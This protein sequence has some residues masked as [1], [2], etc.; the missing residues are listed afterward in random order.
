MAA[1]GDPMPKSIMVQSISGA[2]DDPEM[3]IFD[4]KYK[5]A[6]IPHFLGV[7]IGIADSFR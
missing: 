4:V 7:G 3:G 1:R 6:L 2:W 5:S